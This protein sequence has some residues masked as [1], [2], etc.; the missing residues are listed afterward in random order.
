MSKMK[1][2]LRAL[3]I[4]ASVVF[5]IGTNVAQRPT[6]DPVGMEACKSGTPQDPSAPVCGMTCNSSCG[7]IDGN[8]NCPPCGWCL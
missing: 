1:F 2:M 6:K 3:F 4:A 5:L 7:C 8:P